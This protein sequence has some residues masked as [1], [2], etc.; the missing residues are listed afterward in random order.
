MFAGPMYKETL[1]FINHPKQLLVMIRLA[2]DTRLC[3]PCPIDVNSVSD[4]RGRDLLTQWMHDEHPEF[5]RFEVYVN[6]TV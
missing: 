6:E 4:E 1:T 3:V 2:T 5:D